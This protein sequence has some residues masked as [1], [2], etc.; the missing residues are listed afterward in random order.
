MLRVCPVEGG[1]SSFLTIDAHKNQVT[2]FDPSTYGHST[3]A[4]RRPLPPKMFG[5][6]A[7]F[8]PN[9]PLVINRALFFPLLHDP[10]TYYTIPLPYVH[11]TLKLLQEYY[12]NLP[13][14]LPTYVPIRAYLPT[15]IPTCFPSN[16]PAFQLTY[17]PAF[18]LTYLPTDLPNCCTSLFI[19]ACLPTCIE[20]YL[21]NSCR[22]RLMIR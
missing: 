12:I 4:Y 1:H 21:L 2:A 18:Q 6:D 7:V 19:S 11:W 5:F 9:D 3:S 22:K 13:T 16:L 20:P 17:L 8:A 14:Y 15:C 10:L